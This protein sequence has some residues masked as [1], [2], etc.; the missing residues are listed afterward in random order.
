MMT[1]PLQLSLSPA[2]MQSNAPEFNQ[3]TEGILLGLGYSR[4]EA[5]AL[6]RKEVILGK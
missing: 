5:E 3:H 6:R 4:D 1:W 2:R